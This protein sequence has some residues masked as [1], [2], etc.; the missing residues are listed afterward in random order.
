MKYL[1]LLLSIAGVLFGLT[2]LAAAEGDEGGAKPRMQVATLDA[3]TTTIVNE[4]GAILTLTDNRLVVEEMMPTPPTMGKEDGSTL[5][6]GD[7]IVMING[8][9]VK[10]LDDFR[11]IYDEAEPNAEIKLGVKRDERMQMVT[12]SKMDPE[13]MP[14]T[15]IMMATTDGGGVE[16]V[17]SGG[18]AMQTI[19]ASPSMVPLLEVGLLLDEADGSVIVKQLLPISTDAFAEGEIQAEDKVIAVNGTPVATTKQ[20]SDVYDN[21]AVDA[22]VS[23]TLRRDGAE[24]TVTFAKPESRG[25]I[26]RKSK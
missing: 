11:T 1:S 12:F 7:V 17:S 3:S 22:E 19:E 15:R 2:A 26:I 14:G 4:L 24:R 6:K 20:F 10:A 25:T 13:N 9:R 21:I 23:L 5:E 16:G 8:R 18:M